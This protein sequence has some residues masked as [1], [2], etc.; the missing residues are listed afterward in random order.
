MDL[1]SSCIKP[2]FKM[3]YLPFV[4]D[5]GAQNSELDNAGWVDCDGFHCYAVMRIYVEH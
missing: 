5:E 4:L 1:G 2:F 3:S